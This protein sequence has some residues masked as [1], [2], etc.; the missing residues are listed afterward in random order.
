M[1]WTKLRKTVGAVLILVCA[2]CALL[3]IGGAGMLKTDGYLSGA[4]PAVFAAGLAAFFGVLAG[5]LF[6]KF[7]LADIADSFTAGLLFPRRFAEEPPFETGPVY[8]LMRGPDPAKAEAFLN[9]LPP[10]KK[11]CPGAVLARIELYRDFL[12]RPDEA[13]S[14][15]EGYLSLPRRKQDPCGKAILMAY[16]DLALDAGK[17]ASMLETLKR[18]LELP[19]YTEIEKKAIRLRLDTITRQ[20]GS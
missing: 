10:E 19:V 5:I 18:E 12:K 1:F 16:A 2:A 20:T 14:A 4:G 11:R 9:E 13:L 7:F 3:A 8:A 17:T 15:A 6:C